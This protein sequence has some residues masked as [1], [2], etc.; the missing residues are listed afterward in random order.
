MASVD[1]LD[2]VAKG[3][4]A[5]LKECLDEGADPLACNK[6]NKTS[7]DVAATLGRPE[8][9]KE[10]LSRGIDVN[11]SSRSGYTSLHWAAIWGRLECLTSLVQS[12]ALIS[13]KNRHGE[14]PRDAAARYNQQQC[15]QLLDQIEARNCL[16]ETIQEIRAIL[17]NADKIA[18]KWNKE[19]KAK[20][21]A[22]CN[23]KSNWLDSQPDASP[24]EI[25]N[26][27]DCLQE[28]MQPILAKLEPDVTSPS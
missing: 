22:L 20:T 11:Q 21:T 18:G 12:G 24:D 7:V 5:A 28:A 15:V 13:V 2:F 17:S 25:Y 4:L 8:C 16:K 6:E 14:T 3:D 10:I 1:L 27:R 19:D 23:E 26:K 9:L